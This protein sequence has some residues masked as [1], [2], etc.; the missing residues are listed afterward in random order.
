MKFNFDA[1]I[2]DD[3]IK[4]DIIVRDTDGKFIGAWTCCSTASSLYDAEARAAYQALK[5]AEEMESKH[6]IFE[7]DALNVILALNGSDDH[8]D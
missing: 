4:V 7:G 6:V 3:D 8:L 2:R 5:W 1:S